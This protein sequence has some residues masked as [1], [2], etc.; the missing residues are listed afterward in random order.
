MTD[1]TTYITFND[2]IFQKNYFSNIWICCQTIINIF[3]SAFRCKKDTGL[4][5]LT[6]VLDSRP[7]W[8]GTLSTELL[9]D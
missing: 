1:Y 7:S 4:L 5:I 2:G 3:S 9:T 6:Q 8:Y